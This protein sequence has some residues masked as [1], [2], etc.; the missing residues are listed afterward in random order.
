MNPKHPTNWRGIAALGYGLIALTFGGVGGWAAVTKID[1]AVEA[2]GVVSIETNHKTVQHLEGGIIRA[3]L[4]KEGDNV[5]AGTT[6]FRLENIQAK[7]AFDALDHQLFWALAIEA[8]L[9]AERD[10]GETIAW[11]REIEGRAE[12]SSFSH[13]IADQREDFSKRRDSLQAQIDAL[14]SR[15]KQLA[16]QI[17]GVRVQQESTERQIAFIEKELVGLRALSEKNLVPV[18]RLYAMA[19]ERERLQSVVGQAVTDAAKAQGQIEEHKIEV[20]QLKEKFQEE[21][22]SSLV[23]TRQK[24]SD[25]REKLTVAEDVLRRINVTAPVSGTVQN[26]K[27][28]TV[29][30]VVHPGD[31][32]LDIVPENEPLIVEA[33]FSPTD[34]DGVRAGQ[35]AEI[36]FPTFHSRLIPLLVGRLESI[37]RD[38]LFDEGS[39]QPYYRGIVVLDKAEIP[40]DLR[41]RVRAGMPS[42]VIVASGERTVLNYLVSPL[43][44]TLRTT[45]ID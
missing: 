8:R 13:V 40:E 11:P 1:R 42:E 31:A 18:T 43:S 10:Q 2:A 6:L 15:I 16:I 3:I 27:V 37:S 19:R 38:R 17:E 20:Q 4:V 12:D 32:L 39:K 30:Q 28:F 34:I 41:S 9:I 7:A 14:Q 21:V 29:G 24:I 23:D 45:F 33:Q 5:A 35:E 44:S 22:A 25:L 26:L 36:R